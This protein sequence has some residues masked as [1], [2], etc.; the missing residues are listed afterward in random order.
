MANFV[1]VTDE[2]YEIEMVVDIEEILTI[3]KVAGTNA[4][5]R[6]KSVP[7]G[8]NITPNIYEQLKQILTFK[9]E[10]PE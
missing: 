4:A 10:Y 6:L 8:L 5:M 1:L 7:D 9:E 2:E 3:G